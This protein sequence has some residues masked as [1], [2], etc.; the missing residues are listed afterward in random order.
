M[1]NV[2]VIVF[3][4]PPRAD[5]PPLTALLA[6]ARQ[7]LLEHQVALFRRVG[8]S[9][10][11]LVAGKGAR[12][13]GDVDAGTHGV[14]G[15]HA[16]RGTQ[17]VGD[18]RV[19]RGTHAVGSA[20][21]VGSTHAPRGTH[22]VP[23]DR[24]LPPLLAAT[25]GSFGEALAG[26]VRDEGIEACVV[27]GSGAVPRLRSDDARRLVEL[28]ATPRR[29]ALTNNRYSSDVCAVAEAATL[30]ELPPLRTDNALPRWLEEVAGYSIAELPGRERLALDLDTPLDLALLALAGGPPIMLSRIAAA[31]GLS[32]PRLD[33]VRAVGSDPRREL[34]VFGR[35]SSRTLAWLERHVRC[36]VRFLAEER[37][38]R[39]SSTL[40]MGTPPG[41]AERGTPP[42]GATRGTPPGGAER[43]AARG[44]STRG[45]R[46]GGPTR[47]APTADPVR[48][49]RATIGRLLAARGPDALPSIVA[50]LADAA[51]LDSRV[52]IADRAGP[53]ERAWP[54]DEDRF[55]S[56]LLRPAS[57]ADR[58]LRDLTAAAA[59]SAVPI[60]LGGHTLVGPGVPLLLRGIR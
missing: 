5:D 1:R 3:H 7:T 39:A 45:T 55:A 48:P 24:A 47:P 27:L 41:D 2:T 56:D 13:M 16:P 59:G 19:P 15:G 10:V 20:H 17:A 38:L 52:L 58:W 18:G 29:A 9:R 50:E 22:D 4:R 28:A 44:G 60:L 14:G 49:V 42:G 35:S 51:I 26:L 11:L 53:D 46:T 40:A 57:I 8:A 6:V 31:H 37:G 30:R 12:V 43:D 21:A 32:V 36:R 25:G 33:E 34:L 23:R 54:S